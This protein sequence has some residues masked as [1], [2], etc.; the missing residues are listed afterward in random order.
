MKKIRALEKG[1]DS[2]FGENQLEPI[3]RSEYPEVNAI[4]EWL[5]LHGKPRMS[6]SGGS[7]FLP[8]ENKQHGLTLLQNKP[9]STVGFIAKGMNIHPLLLS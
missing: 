5:S 7:V 4:F 3:V 8:L 9:S 1:I 2:T 6:G